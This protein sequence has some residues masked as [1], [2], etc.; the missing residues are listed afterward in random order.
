MLQFDITKGNIAIDRLLEVTDNPR[1]RFI[2]QA[3][4][5]HRLLEMSGRYDEIFTPEMTVEYP[6]YRFHALGL[7]TTLEGTNQIRAL[8]K[9][10]AETN[11]CI[12]YAENEQVAVADNFVAST[13]VAYQQVW[14]PAVVGEK[15][16]GHLPKCMSKPLLVKMLDI[17]GF[18]ASDD[19]MYLYKSYEETIWPY[20]DR[21]RLKCENVWEPEP[22]D[23]QLI[24][25]DPKDV[26]TTAQAAEKLRPLVKPLPS[27][28][29][30]VF[31]K[32]RTAGA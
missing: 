32:G 25:L 22:K 14:G 11:Q 24:K 8:Y 19:A 12:F 17:H 29:E 3:Y 23:A 16:L 1:H 5:R 6:V 27:F 26:L 2:L 10:W 18:K 20:D 30:M 13:L 21:G 7:A 15:V 4:A 31:G 9:S 28:D